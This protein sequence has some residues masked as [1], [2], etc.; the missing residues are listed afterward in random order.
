MRPGVVMALQRIERRASKRPHAATLALIDA[1]HE[2]L[3]AHNPMTVRQCFYRLV[4]S[5]IVKNEPADYSKVMRV[6]GDA[7]L[8]GRIPWEWIEDR[9]REPTI[10][11]MYDSAEK[12]LKSIAWRYRRD[13]WKN[14]PCYIE[15][16]VE[17]D[18]LS[19]IFENVLRDYRVPLN[20]ARGYSSMSAVKDLADRLVQFDDDGDWPKPV[21]VLHFGDFD[22]EGENAPETIEAALRYHNRELPQMK[23]HFEKIALTTEQIEEYDLPENFTKKAGRRRKRFVE[24]HGD[25][26][27]ELDALPVEVLQELIET[28]IAERMD[29]EALA[30]TRERESRERDLLRQLKLPRR[31][32]PR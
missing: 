6:L 12:F 29:L 21:H 24:T 5:Q 7:R 13:V 19:G 22:P 4:S 32:L 23:I 8:Q 27:V 18:A 14:Q 9:L 30:A 10:W 15:L 17:K 16:I 31:R 26:A 2:V 28:A 11:S 25:R 3:S 20:V 1:C